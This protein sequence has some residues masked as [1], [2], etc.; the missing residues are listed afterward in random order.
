MDVIVTGGAGYIGSHVCKL[1]E[2]LGYRVHV[3]DNLS[4]GRKEF[5]S[6]YQF[7]FLDI[8]DKNALISLFQQIRPIA[9]I[10]LAGKT[11]VS[12][13][14]K[15]P[16]LYDQVN[17][18]G[19]KNLLYA[20]EQSGC[21]R[22]I[23]S[24]T[25]AVFGPVDE[26]IEEENNKNPINPYGKTK[27]LAELAIEAHAQKHTDFSYMIFRYFNA[28]GAHPDSPIGEVHEPE[29]HLIP[30]VIRAALNKTPIQVFG[31][32]YETKDGT[33]IRDYIHVCD[34]AKAHALALKQLRK[35][36]L[37]ESIHIG[38][39]KG[40]SVLEVIQTTQKVMNTTIKRTI[41]PP[42]EGDPPIL[43]ANCQKA[44]EILDFEPEFDLEKMIETAYQFHTK[45]LL[46]TAK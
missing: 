16:T 20:M 4:Q 18:Q 33:C 38:S 29:T 36:N 28:A 43:V 21:K 23:F 30:L 37:Q 22:L 45:D 27:L 34:I 46:L 11:Q 5:V 14:V 9:A 6:N 2:D 31:N 24:S 44:K 32:S 13:S 40:Y 7:H 17:V 35:T 1:L 26:P 3:V 15:N 25:C 41:C 10:H 19:T 12:E 8:L 39:G 42:R